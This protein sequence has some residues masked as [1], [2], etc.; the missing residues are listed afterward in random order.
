ML[1]EK[2]KNKIKDAVNEAKSFDDY[3]S[4]YGKYDDCDVDVAKAKHNYEVYQN[5]LKQRSKDLIKKWNKK[6]IEASNEGKKFFMSN[7]FVTDDDKDKI[8]FLISESNCCVDF[9]HESTLTSFQKYY[10]EK[11]FKV[12]RIEYP[13]N[14]IC[15]LKIIWITSNDT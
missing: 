2:I 9:P 13:A 11:G 8:K 15:C 12:V 6:I 3:V 5:D 10:E 1:W 4:N 7:Q 14:N